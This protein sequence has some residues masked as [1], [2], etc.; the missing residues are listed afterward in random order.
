[1]N[2]DLFNTIPDIDTSNSDE[3]KKQ[4]TLVL[5]NDIPNWLQFTP[6]NE[7]SQEEQDIFERKPVPDWEMNRQINSVFNNPKPIFQNFKMNQIVVKYALTEL[8]KRVRIYT[9]KDLV[10]QIKKACDYINHNLTDYSVVIEYEKKIKSKEWMI[11]EAWKYLDKKPQALIPFGK[12][13]EDGVYLI[14]DDG[15]YSGFQNAFYLKEILS[16]KLNVTIYMVVMFAAEAGIKLIETVLK[17]YSREE[18]SDS[19]KYTGPSTV[20]IWK[21]YITM[22]STLSILKEI[23]DTHGRRGKLDYDPEIVNEIHRLIDTTGS[24]TVFEHKLADFK[25]LPGF[26]SNVFYI[27]MKDHYINT[28]P[29]NPIS[30]KIPT[31]NVTNYTFFGKRK[32]RIVRSISELVY[33]RKFL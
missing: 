23:F 3:F 26:V 28:P 22:Q 5:K 2:P 11:H 18:T 20:Y 25:S 29:Y 32:K 30:G 24:V 13:S 21:G 1:M 33:L 16:K 7:L 4:A 31:E 27:K 15:V 10:D 14:M 9:N 8:F 6:L 19:I 17:G 12:L